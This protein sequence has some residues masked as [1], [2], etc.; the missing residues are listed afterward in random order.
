MI[1][2][3][4]KRLV[5]ALFLLG[6][7][8]IIAFCLSKLVPGDEILDYLSIDESRYSSSAN[9]LQ[10]RQAYAR[11]AEKR[12]LN[13]PLFYITIAHG[14]FPDSLYSIIPLDD[15]QT[16][17]KWAQATR[18][19][20]AVKQLYHTLLSG[21]EFAC[22][23]AD[24][25]VVADQFCLAMHETLHTHD[26]FTAHH[27]ILRLQTLVA[28]NENNDPAYANLVTRLNTDVEQLI[29]TKKDLASSE[30]LPSMYWH[31]TN[32]Q[33]HQW[34]SGFISF[35]PLTSLI[36]GRDAW[37]KI[38][39]ALKWTLLLNGLAFVLA[40]LLGVAIGVWSGTHDGSKIERLI[41]LKLFA[42]YALPSFW[43]A[44]LFIYFL[45]SGE[46]LSILPAG[47]LGSYQGGGHFLEKSGILLKHLILPVLCLS[48]GSLAYVSRQMKQSVLLQLRQPYVLS[49]RTMGVSEKT[50]IHK[51]VF[52]NALFPM[53]T[54]IGGAL[55]ALLSGSLI[56][57]VIF[58]IPGM[59]RLMYTSL[60]AR[61]WPVVFPI[62]MFGATITVLSYILT[63]V[64]YK[65]ADPRVK[66]M[67]R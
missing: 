32:N 15:R 66:S 24:T 62:L 19:K 16:I 36:D 63:D 65:W 55:P 12:G 49:L 47:G 33:Y 50:I 42:L 23:R 60:M 39:D 27:N 46:W 21:L 20:D 9:P 54:L 37:G 45:S 38:F 67:E 56:I 10:H 31:G 44:T 7:I 14:Y 43:L 41:N 40:I 18:R 17:K 61:D 25:S 51:H 11:V 52:R 34:M 58:S 3:L 6:V 48:L 64:I 53:I 13:L 22:P 35:A 5:R 4:L 1:R 8:S 30:W 28:A 29:N 26:L 59:G 2:S 57:E